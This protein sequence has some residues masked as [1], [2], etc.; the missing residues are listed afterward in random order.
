MARGLYLVCPN[1]TRHKRFTA[2][3][4][5]YEYWIVDENS[6]YQQTTE[7]GDVYQEPDWKDDFW[8]IDCGAAAIKREEPGPVIIIPWPGQ[9]ATWLS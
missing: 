9:K 3:A 5:V 2:T 8:C 6:D 4:I 7:T 1:N